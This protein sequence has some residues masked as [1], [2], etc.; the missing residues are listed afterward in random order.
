ME[1]TG[2][3]DAKWIPNAG[4]R[5]RPRPSTPTSPR[6]S[7][8]SRR[9]PRTSGS[10]SSTP[11]SGRSSSRAWSCSPPPSRPSTRAS[12]TSPR[13]GVRATGKIGD[14]AY[15]AL[16]SDDRGGGTRDHPGPLRLVVRPPGLRVARGGGA[17]PARPRR[18]VR[19]L[20]RAPTGRSRAAATTGCSAPTSSGGPT[21]RTRSPGR[22]S[23]QLHRDP[24]PARPR[25]RVGRPRSSPAPAPTSGGRTARAASTLS[26]EVKS[27]GDGFRAD[28]GFV[29][30]VGFR[31]GYVEAG[32]TWYPTGFLSRVR[33]FAFA[34]PMWDNQGGMIRQ[35]V[36][37]GVGMD[38]R[39][40]SFARFCLVPDRWRVRRA[41]ARARSLS[42]R[43]PRPS[44]ASSSRPAPRCGIAAVPRGRARRGDRLRQRPAR[45]RRDADPAPSCAPTTTSPSAST[46][47]GDGSTSV[48]TRAAPRG[49]CSRPRSSG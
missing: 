34:D 19:Q 26:A 2:G 14:T 32:R 9:S 42:W 24:R 35:L 25:P 37:A 28:A 18:I 23:T 11:R 30:Q 10:R 4:R 20:S 39:W 47:P 1:A 48:P 13:W 17:R 40:S 38:G 29:P 7:R 15:T 49:G 46:P 36:A 3:L 44:S 5:P 27:F 22:S 41:G 16:I 31:E 21:T 43:S 45:S 8:T 12:I 33:A 6:S